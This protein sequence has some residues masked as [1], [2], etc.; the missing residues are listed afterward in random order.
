M[1]GLFGGARVKNAITVVITFM[2]RWI[3]WLDLP[4][5]RT[6][7]GDRRDQARR[8]NLSQDEAFQDVFEA[9]A[10]AVLHWTG[11]TVSKSIPLIPIHI[12]VY[13]V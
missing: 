1:V 8:R 12:K 7:R 9:I 10:R 13:L 11:R 5:E 4:V 2:N 3:L 6:V